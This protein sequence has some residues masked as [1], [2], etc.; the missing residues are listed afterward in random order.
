M[1]LV[2]LFAPTLPRYTLHLRP[3]RL[4]HQSSV[5]S[6]CARRPPRARLP[7]ETPPSTPMHPETDESFV[8]VRVLSIG[9][10]SSDAS[11]LTLRP[12]CGGENAFKMSITP[13]QADSIMAAL[14]SRYEIRPATHD[15]FKKTI[16][17]CGVFVTYAA[18]THIQHDVFIASICVRAG[19]SVHHLDARPSDAVAMAARCC[20]PVY[21]Q[22]SLLEKWRVRVDSVE[23]DA[24]SGLCELVE[25]KENI[26]TSTSIRQE[27]RARPEHLRLAKLKMELDLAVRLERFGEA[28]ALRE[29]IGRICP[30]DQLQ[31]E[32]QEALKEERFKDAAAIQDQITVW[33]ARLRMW[34]KGTID[35]DDFSAG[36]E[37]EGI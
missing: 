20:A 37:M 24:A 36:E 15:L 14:R 30:I 1:P 10:A 3:N 5:R 31:H 22:T 35:L 21:L 2:P 7:D 32:L 9:R 12:V 23:Q 13:P 29:T 25:Y 34:E 28:T 11:L 33:K 18:I 19:E 27:V 8:E 17:A 16:D 6:P 26:K 4:L